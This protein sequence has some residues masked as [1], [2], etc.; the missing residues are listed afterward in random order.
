MNKTPITPKAH[1]IIDYVISGVLLAA[2]SLI[3]TN[4]KAAKAYGVV[5]AGMTALNAFTDTPAGLKKS[6]PFVGHKKADLSLLVGL[7]ALSFASFIRKDKRALGFHLTFLAI[8]TAY[9]FLTDYKDDQSN[10]KLKR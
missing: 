3:G 10:R 2:P 5:S 7:S 8:T 4:S 9:Y 6:I 1:G